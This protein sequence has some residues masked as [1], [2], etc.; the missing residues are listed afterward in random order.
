MNENKN[1]KV[2][3]WT[4][5]PAEVADQICKTGEFKCDPNL[6]DQDFKWAYDWMADQMEKKFGR[7]EDV[8]L[9][10]WGWYR[11]YGKNKK[12]DLRRGDYQ[13]GRKGTKLACI[14][15]ELPADEVLLSDEPNWTMFVLNNSFFDSSL[16][17]EESDALYAAY[18]ALPP[19]EQEKAKKESWQHVFEIDPFEND[20][21]CRGQHVQATFWKIKKEEIKKITYF[22]SKAPAY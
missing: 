4:I 12:P 7:P 3:A 19:Q 17:E 5:Q 10:V 11:C 9:P 6:C 14:E 15:L 13:F 2:R 8:T 20:W 1:C 21:T 22:V 18:K 16:S